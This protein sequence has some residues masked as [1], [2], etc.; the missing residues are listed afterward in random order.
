[1]ARSKGP[2]TVQCYHCRHRFQAAGRAESTSCPGCHKPLFVGDITVNQLKGPLKEIR[3]CGQ[4]LVK[5]RGRVI[6]EFIE[7]HDGIQCM[8]I[9]DAKRVISGAAVTLG[10]KSQFKGSL[11]A[12][13]LAIQNGAR[14]LGGNFNIPDHT[15]G[16]A[17]LPENP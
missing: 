13:T 7:A 2:R 1:M 3:T 6:A 10:P 5:K 8:G 17:D 11:Q 15:L 14:V 4:I 9:I 12:P 16:L